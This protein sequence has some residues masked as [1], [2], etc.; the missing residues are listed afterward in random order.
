M[1]IPTSISASTNDTVEPPP[2]SLPQPP[3]CRFRL[4]TNS[5]ATLTLPSGRKLGYAQYGSLTGLPIIYLHGL[6]G[7][8]LEA[9]GYDDIALE[10]GARI[11]AVDRPGMGWS[12]PHPSRTLLGFTEDIRVLAEHLGLE[13]YAVLGVSGG[14]PYTLACAFALPRENLKCASLVCG[15]GPMDIGMGGADLIQRFGFPWGWLYTPLFLLRWFYRRTAFGRMEFS[16]EERLQK[17]REARLLE[18]MSATDREIMGDD[19]IMRLSLR[20][21]REAVV[22]GFEGVAVDGRVMCSDWGFRVEDVR[23]DLPVLLWYGKDDMSVPANHGVHIAKR[24]SEDGDEGRVV[25]RVE[26]ETHAS[27][28]YKWKKEQLEAILEKLRG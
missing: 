20:S 11:I 5:S 3:K 17:L 4:D 2:S 6:P 10:M 13:T 23:K 9:A 27:I 18:K 8:R 14:G 25:F 26:E 16:D 12:S 19:D 1:D 24:L 7:S 21:S 22:Q 28:S 15:L